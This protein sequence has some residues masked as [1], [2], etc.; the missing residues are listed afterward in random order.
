MARTHLARS[1]FT[2]VELLVVIA[3]IGILIALLLPAVQAAREAARRAECTNKIKQIGLAL[4]NYHDTHK[5][6]PPGQLSSISV[7][8]SSATWC[9]SGSA[10]STRAP[11][12]VLILPYLEQLNL[13]NR[14]DFGR[15]FTGFSVEPGVTVNNE[16]F[17]MNNRAYQCP[18]D[19]N[20]TAD[21]NNGCYFGVQGGGTSPSCPAVSASRVFFIN[22][23]LYQNSAT[24]FAD[25]LD[26]TSNVF[27]VGESKYCL[28]KIIR[29]DDKAHM[30]WASGGRLSASGPTPMVI[31]ATML[32]INARTQHGGIDP[33]VYEYTSRVFGSFHPGGCQFGLADGSVHFVSETIDINLY[34]QLG[35]R[36]DGLPLGGLQ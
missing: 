33:Y 24:R 28:N 8:H 21:N 4:H 32:Q 5:V 22:G 30:G 14:F 6:L 26:G 31:A 3:I 17:E 13:H 7:N 15:Q 12:T 1:A 25:I 27:L 23:I 34:R 19:P 35:I 2:L 20:S 9:S 16:L 36:N 18:S 11:W 10:A 29:P